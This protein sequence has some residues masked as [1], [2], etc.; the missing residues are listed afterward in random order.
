VTLREGVM[1]ATAAIAV[2]TRPF[3]RVDPVLE[4]H[5]QRG[6]KCSQPMTSDHCRAENGAGKGCKICKNR[7][8]SGARRGYQEERERNG[9]G[10]RRPSR[11]ATTATHS[12]PPIASESSLNSVMERT[13]DSQSLPRGRVAP[14][15]GA[16]RRA[17]QDQ[18]RPSDSDSER[19]ALRAGP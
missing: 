3:F 17:R 5:R 18:Q 10:P 15:A 11:N 1:V 13:R 12:Q 2:R 9:E 8:G 7:A 4:G 6:A 14:R 16:S 19:F